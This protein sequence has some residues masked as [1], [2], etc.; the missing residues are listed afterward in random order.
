MRAPG[1]RSCRKRPRHSLLTARPGWCGQVVSPPWERLLAVGAGGF[2]HLSAR[3]QQ[4]HLRINDTGPSLRCLR[5]GPPIDHLPWM[6]AA[7]RRPRMSPDC[8]RSHSDA[9]M[10]RRGRGRERGR[11]AGS[12]GTKPQPR[13]LA[14]RSSGHLLDLQE[15]EYLSECILPGQEVGSELPLDLREPPAHGMHSAE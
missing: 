10:P 14:A 4:Q 8:R 12:N 13:H 2:E 1:P 7:A 5:A 9:R 6:G 3:S 11:V 15:Y